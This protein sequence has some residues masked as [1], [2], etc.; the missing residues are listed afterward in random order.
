MNCASIFAVSA[1]QGGSNPSG[2][3]PQAEWYASNYS[4]KGGDTITLNNIST[5]NPTSYLWYLN[6]V[7]FS[8][9]PSPIYYC[10][11]PGTQVFNLVVSNIYGSTNLQQ[12]IYVQN[13]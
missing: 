2:I 9:V 7:L 1:P 6:G 13:P 3:P 8:T 10:G 5:G 4:P 12:S 11:N